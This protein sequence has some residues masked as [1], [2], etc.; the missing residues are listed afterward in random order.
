MLTLCLTGCNTDLS[1]LEINVSGDS[2]VGSTIQLTLNT[3]KESLSDV[4]WQ[5]ES[6]PSDSQSTMQIASGNKSST[7][8]PDIAGQYH[9]LVTSIDNETSTGTILT[10]TE[11]PD[12]ATG[13]F[14]SIGKTVNEPVSLKFVWPE[15]QQEELVWEIEASPNGSLSELDTS[16]EIGEVS[17]IPEYEGD[18]T[19][20]VSHEGTGQSRSVSIAVF[21]EIEFDLYMVEGLTEE[22]DANTFVGE[23]RNQFVFESAVIPANEMSN[24]IS[25]YPTLNYLGHAN[26]IGG[27]HIVEFDPESVEALQDIEKLK[28]DEQLYNVR[29]R[30]YVGNQINQLNFEPNDYGSDEDI[31]TDNEGANW[32]LER[33]NMPAAWDLYLNFM[34]GKT[35]PIYAVGICDG[36]LYQDHEDFRQGTII[37]DYTDYKDE[38]STITPT[39]GTKVTGVIS[40]ETNNDQG[41][42][43]INFDA[44]IITGH[45][46]QDCLS[47]LSKSKYVRVVNNSYGLEPDSGNA[48]DF[49]P[50]DEGEVRLFYDLKKFENRSLDYLYLKD[51]RDAS[52]KLYVFAA[53]NGYHKGTNN[54][55]A[56]LE[57]GKAYG[58]DAKYS[59]YPYV[60]KKGEIENIIT[61]AATTT[62]DY[63]IHYSNY[64]SYVDIAAPT[65]FKSTRSNTPFNK[66]SDG[67]NYGD[68]SPFLDLVGFNGTSASAPIVSGVASL[69]FEINPDFTPKQVKDILISSSTENI[70]QR[71]INPE[72]DVEDTLPIPLLNAERAIQR[73]IDIANNDFVTIEEN[74]T[75]WNP[76]VEI[77][78]SPQ[79]DNFI[80]SS[81]S[82]TVY[83]YSNEG[84]MD[85]LITYDGDGHPG[86]ELDFGRFDNYR[87]FNISGHIIYTY[88]GTEIKQS[89]NHIYEPPLGTRIAIS[90]SVT[91]EPMEG[92]TLVL[93]RRGQVT[94]PNLDSP[95]YIKTDNNGESFLYAKR[96]EFRVTASK[97]GYQDS[98]FNIT[99]GTNQSFGTQ[100]SPENTTSSPELEASHEVKVIDGNRNPVEGATVTVVSETAR[101]SYLT[102]SR[103]A[104]IVSNYC[105]ND[106]GDTGL[107]YDGPFTIEISKPGYEKTSKSLIFVNGATTTKSYLLIR[108][109]GYEEGSQQVLILKST[110]TSDDTEYQPEGISKGDEVVF[111]TDF[112]DSA[113]FS[114]EVDYKQRERCENYGF[115]S[116][117]V[118]PAQGYRAEWS[119]GSGR[120][121]YMRGPDKYYNIQYSSGYSESFPLDYVEVINCGNLYFY[122]DQNEI[123]KEYTGEEEFNFYHLGKRIYSLETEP[124]NSNGVKKRIHGYDEI[125]EL[126]SQ[127]LY[128][129]NGTSNVQIT[130]HRVYLDSNSWGTRHE[131]YTTPN[132]HTDV[133][134]DSFGP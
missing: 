71:Y 109:P 18:Y 64:G 3:N 5:I 126:F 52:N 82:L 70:T 43:S 4:L 40:A 77:E 79:D 96:E 121:F 58:L 75:F 59:L 106:C 130:H 94:N 16:I 56:N 25:Q 95:I 68:N 107:V 80:A 122:N 99:L 72:G 28:L 89:I 116:K 125:P 44:K 78:F 108:G 24:H 90:N 22:E 83:G 45:F 35:Y 60:A 100:L 50:E 57:H 33:I 102:D 66:Y 97:E 104:A 127:V 20:K 67:L 101:Y 87:K 93:E 17:F 88:N 9:I 124:H 1:D 2:Y 8:V 32:H 36:G 113:I 23:I 132:G 115:L 61:V 114:S 15:H 120:R 73:A 27:G 81:F 118:A 19:L 86:L 85:S 26:K 21:N 48:P 31:W 13:Y 7:L 10:I 29:Q 54:K 37:L 111:I 110:V 84:G 98:F 46:H 69:I 49:H 65:S 105:I 112:E 42:A 55:E 92:V 34:S 117:I 133:T 51:N 63:L 74:L 6:K 14:T 128:G 123:E 12:I 30:L 91:G 76:G 41:I 11:K 47:E 53:G 119:G 134:V 131:D 39:H 129:I 62:D 38:N 103:G